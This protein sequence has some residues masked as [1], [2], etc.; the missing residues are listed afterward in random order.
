MRSLRRGGV[1]KAGEGVGDCPR[2][3][4]HTKKSRGTDYDPQSEWVGREHHMRRI[5]VVLAAMAAMVVVYAGAAL[6]ANITCPGGPIVCAGTEQNDR[7]TGSQVDDNIQALGGL[8]VV[9]ARA[10]DDGVDGG[11]NRD[12]IFGGPGGDG[13]F[14]GLGPDDIQGGRGTTASSEPPYTFDCTLTEDETG[15]VLAFTEGTQFLV[16]D[17][18]LVGAPGGNDDLDGGI[19]NDFLGGDAGRNDLSGSGGDDCL[20]LTGDANERASGGDGDDLIEAQDGNADDVICGAGDDWVEADA[21]DRVAAN[22]EHV[23]R[24]SAS[25]I[26]A[27]GATPVVEVNI[28]TPEGTTTMTP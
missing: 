12:D 5:I 28:T 14:G 24:P 27:T 21:N 1:L 16:G 11:R 7:I 8:D 22:C 25:P 17:N 4:K 20:L 18:N 15:P 10:G 19:D 2:P 23:L 3:K 6:A 9:T 13:L 26:Q